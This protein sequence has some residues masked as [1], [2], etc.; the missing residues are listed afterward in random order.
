[1]IPLRRDDDWAMV[2]L[3]PLGCLTAGIQRPGRPPSGRS[4]PLQ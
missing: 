4:G 2:R 1:M 3:E